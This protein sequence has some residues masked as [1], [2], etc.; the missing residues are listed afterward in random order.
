MKYN[1]MNLSINVQIFISS[2]Q[3]QAWISFFMLKNFKIV[4]YLKFS[5]GVFSF[6]KK[7]KVSCFLFLFFIY[8]YHAKCA[9][10]TQSGIRIPLTR[11]PLTVDRLKSAKAKSRSF[12]TQQ[13]NQDVEIPLRDN[14]LLS[15]Y[16]PI[17]IGTPP[18]NFNVVFDTGSYDLWVPSTL[19]KSQACLDPGRRL[20]N[21]TTSKTRQ[22]KECKSEEK[23]KYGT[24][25]MSGVR[26]T[27]TLTIDNVQ[28]KNRQFLEAMQEA[29][30]FVGE[31]YDGIMGLRY[32]NT[33]S[34]HI[35]TQICKQ[36][37]YVVSKFSV[38]LTNDPKN[39]NGGELMLCDE[40]KTKYRGELNYASE[41]LSGSWAVVMKKI[42]LRYGNERVQ[43]LAT[44]GSGFFDTG[45]SFVI[46]PG[47]YVKAIY[48]ALNSTALEGDM[49]VNCETIHK[50]PNITFRIQAQDYT[51][52][53][54][55]Y[56]LKITAND[57]KLHCIVGFASNVASQKQW[58]LG[59]VFLRKYYTVYDLNK[60]RIGLA[61]SI[62]N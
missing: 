3:K 35:V 32:K 39:T 19:C 60:R 9:S 1:P 51:L 21:R 41:Y 29:D 10:I 17:S 4:L 50:L 26:S 11:N 38:Y 8:A 57:G 31:P 52:A 45:S 58:I 18:Q 14:K 48:K 24:G 55:D 15:Y 34:N 7:M 12:Y 28:I 46:G 47:K 30:G 54:R 5:T 61:E 6:S 20:Y 40:D 44:D 56:I 37:N 22:C 36:L 42:S 13:L 53:G 62:H 25:W 2:S 27:D 43:E 59:D 49:E 23:I 16:G 33:V